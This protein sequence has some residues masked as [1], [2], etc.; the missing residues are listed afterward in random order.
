MPTSGPGAGQIP[1]NRA[2]GFND[3]SAALTDQSVKVRTIGK[4]RTITGDKPQTITADLATSPYLSTSPAAV[5]GAAAEATLPATQATLPGPIFPQSSIV[6]GNPLVASMSS[7]SEPDRSSNTLLFGARRIVN[8]SAEKHYI[9]ETGFN[10]YGKVVETEIGSPDGRSAGVIANTDPNNRQIIR[11]DANQA[12]GT[13]IQPTITLAYEASLG[14]RGGGPSADLK[15]KVILEGEIAS[16]GEP[17]LVVVTGNG[18]QI[19]IPETQKE[20]YDAALELFIT[21]FHQRYDLG[22]NEPLSSEVPY[23]FK[24]DA[25]SVYSYA[26]GDG[27]GPYVGWNQDHGTATPSKTHFDPIAG[28]LTRTD[29]TTGGEITSKVENIAYALLLDEGQYYQ[30][31]AIQTADGHVTMTGFYS[32]LAGKVLESWF[33]PSEA[34]AA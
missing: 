7:M 26:N 27:D 3:F 19:L 5:G 16:T 34:A 12:F 15:I 6:G 10:S 24:V 8:A 23:L 22:S 20:S 31:L 33:P 4:S 17:A 11:L 21:Q 28:T 32:Q 25:N 1:S 13:G 14:V 9:F 2:A 18:H 30:M 29:A